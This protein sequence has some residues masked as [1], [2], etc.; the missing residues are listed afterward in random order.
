MK[1]IQLTLIGLV[2]TAAALACIRAAPPA[3]PTSWAVSPPLQTFAGTPTRTPFLPPTRGPNEPILTPTPDQPRALPTLRA[4][5]EQYVVQPGDSLGTIAQQYSVSLGF[6]INANQLGNPDLLT[7][8]QV[9]TIPAPQPVAQ[10]PAFKIIPDSEL[11]YGPVSAYVDYAALVKRENGFLVSYEDEIDEQVTSGLEI[12]NRVAQDYS[13]NPLLLLAILEYQSEWIT[14]SEPIS[15]TRTYPIGLYNSWRKGLY[16]QLVWTA[17]ELNRGYYL[18]RVN[19][20]GAWV[21]ADGSV[22]PIAP[23][24]NAGTAAIQHFFSQLYGQREWSFAISPNGLFRTYSGL[25]GYPFDLSVD[26]LLPPDLAQPLLQLPFEP[27]KAW[28]FTGGPHGGWADGSAWAALDFAPPG[29]ALG[30]VTTNDWVVAVADGPIVRS[31]NGAV[32]QDLDGD[33]LEQTGWT[34]L[35]MHIETRDRVE[36]G[37]YVKAGERIGHPSCEGGI[38]SGTHVHLARRYNGEWIPADQEIPFVM[39]GWVSVGTGYQYDGYLQKSGSIVEAY[40]RRSPYNLIE[41]HNEGF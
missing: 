7:V 25:F 19:G 17:N 1:K 5:T 31:G 12:V 36:A 35:Y 37:A 4:E 13:V 8:G 23:T 38:S 11:V 16:S 29:D 15:I 30:C 3:D 34:I 20:V 21:L 39:D 32:V 10:G 41:R 22:V 14:A 40:A 6:L 26:P 2:L 28:A 24:L 27:G 9:L 18:W 33:G